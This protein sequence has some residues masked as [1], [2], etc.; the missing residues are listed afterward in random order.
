V[1]APIAGILLRIVAR[2]R[3]PVKA[4]DLLCV[5]E[6]MK[7]ENEVRA[8]NPGRV[9]RWLASA[10][11]RVDAGGPLCTLLAPGPQHLSRVGGP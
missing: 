9:G 2:E 7:M 3:Q 10:G 1:R 11:Q 8:A 4:G 5:I 6:A